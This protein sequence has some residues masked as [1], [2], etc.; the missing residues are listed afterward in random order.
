MATE[1]YSFNQAG[2]QRIVEAVRRVER[3][4]KNTARQDKRAQRASPQQ[5]FLGKT[6]A[7]HAAGATR[8]ISIWTGTPGSEADSTYNLTGVY[9]RFGGTI[10]SGTWV[11]CANNGYGWYIIQA[12]CP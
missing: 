8:T 7:S 11:W 2:A 10:A 6:D 1:P 12:K 3:M 5:M 9:Y 4:P